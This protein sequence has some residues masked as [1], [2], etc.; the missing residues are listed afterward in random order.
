MYANTSLRIF[1][2][3]LKNQYLNFIYFLNV[4]TTGEIKWIYWFTIEKEGAL[5]I[6][7][8]LFPVIGDIQVNNHISCL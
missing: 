2:L 3:D 6:S 7:K 4:K 5:V 8:V 1:L